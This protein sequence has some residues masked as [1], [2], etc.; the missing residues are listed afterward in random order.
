M[1]QSLPGATNFRKIKVSNGDTLTRILRRTI[2]NASKLQIQNLIGQVRRISSDGKIVPIRDSSAIKT[3]EVVLVPIPSEL[4]NKHVGGKSKLPR[5][6]VKSGHGVIN[7]DGGGALTSDEAAKIDSVLQLS[8]D[9]LNKST[10]ALVGYKT[11]HSVRKIIETALAPGNQGDVVTEKVANIGSVFTAEQWKDGVVQ[12]KEK[13]NSLVLELER[14]KK[15]LLSSTV[16]K[17]T[18]PEPLKTK[19]GPAN[20]CANTINMTIIV[21]PTSFFGHGA[22]RPEI[23]ARTMIHEAGHLLGWGHAEDST[24]PGIRQNGTDVLANLVFK[25][26]TSKK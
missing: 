15:G 4:R 10:S 17:H 13:F 8:I 19:D 25:L 6:S 21:E 5:V 2:P 14:I 18:G 7:A 23:C 22:N 12:L 11:N 16:R 9:F 26:A 24:D 20:A 3:G 1:T